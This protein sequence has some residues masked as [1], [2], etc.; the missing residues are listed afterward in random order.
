MNFTELERSILTKL[1]KGMLDGVVGS[2]YRSK[3]NKDV[4]YRNIIENGVPKAIQLK[5]KD[6]FFDG[7]D[8]VIISDAETVVIFETDD[9]KL[10][11]MQKY[12]WL[13]DDPDARFYS[14]FFKP[15][16]SVKKRKNRI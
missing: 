15:D 10:T 11:F 3:K 7:R 8:K 12:G 2:D 1:D 16:S 4:I 6:E 13:M 9:E 5:P 14:S